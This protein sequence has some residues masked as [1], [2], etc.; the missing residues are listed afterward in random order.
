[1][2]EIQTY[3][4]VQLVKSYKISYQ[5]ISPSQSSIMS[6]IQECSG[7]GNCLPAIELSASKNGLNV[8]SSTGIAFSGIPVG[9]SI[10]TRYSQEVPN[11]FPIDINGDGL[12]DFI[13]IVC[14]TK[15]WYVQA[16]CANSANR[17]KN[18]YINIGNNTFTRDALYSDSLPES[19]MALSDHDGGVKIVDINGDGLPD[20]VQSYKRNMN[21][22]A[23]QFIYLN[24]G[25][26]FVFD[27]Q[28]SKSIPPIFFANEGGGDEGNQNGA[29]SW[30]P[31]IDID[32]DGLLDFVGSDGSVYL[33]T[34]KGF[35]FDPILS[36]NLRSV[37]STLPGPVNFLDKAAVQFIDLNGDGRPDLV[38]LSWVD[39]QLKN[40]GNRKVFLNTPQGF[41]YDA[42]YSNSLPDIYMT[43]SS[44]QDM[45]TRFADLNGDGLPDIIQLYGGG[46]YGLYGGGSHQVVYLNT[47]KSFSY[48]ESFTNSLPA[49]K[50][51]SYGQYQPGDEDHATFVP[52]NGIRLVD[53]NG[54]GLID[55]VETLNTTNG[56]PHIY[57][58]TGKGFLSAIDLAGGNGPAI[59]TESGVDSQ[60]RFMDFDGDALPD[61]VDL[62]GGTSQVGNPTSFR[63]RIFKNQFSIT[64]RFISKINNNGLTTEV[65]YEPLTNPSVYV[66]D[67]D[68]NKATLPNFDLQVA[69]YV[70][71]SA[72]RSN[73]T[74][75]VDF[76]N[77]QYGG[78][79]IQRDGRGDLG[80]RWMKETDLNT[81]IS[82]LS[83]FRQ[84]WPYIG[85]VAKLTTLFAGGGSNGILSQELLDYRCL[86]SVN[87]GQSCTNNTKVYFP[88]SSNS[89]KNAWDLNG[90]ILPQVVTTQVYD[91][92]GNL[93]QKTTQNGDLLQTISNTYQ[94]VVSSWSIGLLTNNV[95]T[96]NSSGINVVPPQSPPPSLIV[97]RNPNPLISNQTFTTTWLTTNATSVSMSCQ[98]AGTGF[99][100]DAILP[101]VNGTTTNVAQMSWVNF[102]STCT[103]VATGPGGSTSYSEQ[104][105]TSMGTN[106]AINVLPIILNLLLQD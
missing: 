5:Q 27:D 79:K 55:L 51:F 76:K 82:S 101:T 4:G 50:F 35:V 81:G 70:V 100:S 59:Q 64:D 7:A 3:T 80:F 78:W 30:Q 91:Q 16:Q 57:L 106:S 62:A 23:D 42:G 44:G 95:I 6:Q 83:E 103:W 84:D 20:I 93:V 12:I 19:Y 52:D 43:S 18:V 17:V 94:N 88:Y 104:L 2:S 98:A 61:M 46:M 25:K 38:Y 56:N 58:N 26:G 97:S 47:G 77:Y 66:R 69:K 34:G 41:L 14:G 13:Q 74:G 71:S 1:M 96:Q 73:G 10:L 29:N 75:G 85:I 8:V 37:F 33:N 39:E 63:N 40:I 15:D 87:A 68:S 11:A 36:S 54:D 45:G 89:T 49:G 105:S 72:S 60:G 32:G 31:L 9:L 86:D 24:N 21:K 99:N 53:V 22:P 67:V 48:S 65:H 102:P 92:W 28:Y 90:A